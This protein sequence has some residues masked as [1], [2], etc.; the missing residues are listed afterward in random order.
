[1]SRA[2]TRSGSVAVSTML[3]VS[4]VTAAEIAARTSAA[5]TSPPRLAATTSDRSRVFTKSTIEV[6]RCV[7]NRLPEYAERRVAAGGGGDE[8]HRRRG[9][10]RCRLDG[11]QK[12]D[13]DRG[14]QR[15]QHD[16]PPSADRLPVVPQFHAAVRSVRGHR[17]SSS[18]T[19]VVSLR[20]SA[21][22]ISRRSPRTVRPLPHESSAA[23]RDATEQPKY[24]SDP[25]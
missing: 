6:T 11:Q 2:S 8:D 12:R 3:E 25:R 21:S 9:V 15:G 18:I 5:A 24:Q 20:R 19:V 4:G 16:P 14:G 13:T 7:A 10:Q 22:A 23:A 1:M 17:C